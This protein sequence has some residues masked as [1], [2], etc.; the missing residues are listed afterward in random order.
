MGKT[1]KAEGRSQVLVTWITILGLPSIRSQG[2]KG[3]SASHHLVD[4]SN[5]S[6]AERAP[7]GILWITSQVISAKQQLWWGLRTGSDGDNSLDIGDTKTNSSSFHWS[8]RKTAV[9]KNQGP[10]AMQALHVCNP[11]LYPSYSV[12]VPLSS[13]FFSHCMADV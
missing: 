12:H 5:R 6:G 3:M 7:T 11:V 4:C 8:A 13:L 9:S 1:R 2:K 10:Y